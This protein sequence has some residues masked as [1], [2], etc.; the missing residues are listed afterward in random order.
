MRRLVALC[1]LLAFGSVLAGC[2]NDEDIE[3]PTI[4]R[5]VQED[6]R[7][8]RLATAL[9]ATGLQVALRQSGPFTLFAPTDQAFAGLPSGTFD[10]LLQN[11]ADL[12]RVLQYHVV[13]ARLSEA[14]LRALAD[15]N[16]T[17]NTL[18]NASLDIRS[19]GGALILNPSGERAFVEG[20]AMVASNGVVYPINMVLVPPLVG[21]DLVDALRFDPQF[22]R[23]VQLLEAAALENVLRQPGPFT[24]FAPTDQAFARLP[25]ST[26]DALIADPAQLDRV[27]RFHVVPGRFTTAD[28]RGLSSLGTLLGPHFAITSTQMDTLVLGSAFGDALLIRPDFGVANGIIHTID[29]VLF[30]PSGL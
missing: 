14:E 26:L 21:E 15:Q 4:T 17:L 8:S 7:F 3:A 30:P 24:L 20:D 22:A 12:S 29:N 25:A 19:A 28:L 11:P 18:Q 9:Q 16:A 1:A 23:L 10:L 6:G 5:L 27:L 13:P 2:A